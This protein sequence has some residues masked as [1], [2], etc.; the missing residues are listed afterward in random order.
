MDIIV[1][2]FLTA[3]AFWIIMA[4]IGIQKFVQLGWA[5]D[6]LI[7]GVIAMLFVGTFTGMVTGLIAGIFISLFLGIAKMFSRMG[8]GNHA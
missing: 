3:I 8:R 6:L 2:A 1:I 5:A 7:S 4:K